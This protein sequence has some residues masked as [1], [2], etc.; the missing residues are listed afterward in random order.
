MTEAEIVEIAT[1]VADGQDPQT[2][3]KYRNASGADQK[4]I[5]RKADEMKPSM[6]N[7]N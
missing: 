6:Q 1:L 4:S 3:A 2:I 5:D 7:P